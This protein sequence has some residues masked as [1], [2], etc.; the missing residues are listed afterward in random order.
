MQQIDIILP[1]YNPLQNW[2]TRI[3]AATS[4][5]QALNPNIQLHVILVNDGSTKGILPEQLALLEQKLPQFSYINYEKNKGK[6]HALRKGV[7]HSTSEICIYTD[8]DFPYTTTS[9]SAILNQLLIPSTQVAVGTRDETYYEHV[10]KVR[11]RISKIFRFFIGKFFFLKV[12]DTQCGLK[13]FRS[14]GKALFLQTTTDRYLFDLE[15][16]QLV[17]KKLPKAIVAVPVVLKPNVEFSAM[18][19]PVLAR[20]GLSF[21]QI[22]FKNLFRG[23]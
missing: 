20:E 11:I 2:E 17:S 16:I 3:L 18:N 22:F 13:G 23:K 21:V 1:C 10:P 19:F 4:D 9:I 8:I 14:K 12:T 6:G 7:Q 5:F 15:F